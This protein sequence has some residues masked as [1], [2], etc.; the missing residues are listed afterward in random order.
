MNEIV[1]PKLSDTMTE[2]RLISWK[3]RVGEQVS[4]GEVL[5]EVE[6]DKANMELEAFVSGVLLEIRVEPG[7]MVPVGTVIAAIGAAEE[8]GQPA[9]GEKEEQPPKGAEAQA[10]AQPRADEGAKGETTAAP[11]PPEAG[12][13]A[14][15]APAGQPVESHE[16]AAP[17]VRRRARE[18]G[19]DLATVQGSG[20]EGRILLKDL[21]GAQQR[22]AAGKPAA[23]PS[24]PEG[25]AQP[26]AA[27]ESSESGAKLSRLR[28]A[29][30]K[31]VSDSWRAIPH[32]AVTV[33]VLMDDAEV[34]RRQLK[35]SGRA[36]T[37]TDL[38]VKA[39]ALALLKYPQL[40]ASL[41]GDTLRPRADLNICVAVAVPDGV[42]M[43]VIRG[44]QDLT[45]VEIAEASHAI[46][47]KARS[48]NLTEQDM[49]G[50][51]FAV[52]NLGMYGVTQFAA[53]IFP[54]HAAV[55]AVGGVLESV[56][57]RNGAPACAK[58]MKVTISADHRVVDGA[59][60]AQFLAEFKEILENPIR[61]LI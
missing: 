61:L 48:G 30:A 1:M 59:Y 31:N 52:S 13:A 50:G 46:A 12:G 11:P 10:P 21:E 26:T 55:L 14:A 42:L 57:A 23:P 53:I 36:V 45:L 49:N 16:R 35:Q 19:V 33:D 20:P 15:E 3:K 28:A 25:A 60:A 2:G 18:L 5:A 43:P 39:S 32:F 56:V 17:V 24:M 7:D 47:E 40:N 54:S 41:D 44:C 38:V 4:R 27:S 6:T 51:S 9:A 58:V 8:K 22:S 37:L 34:M 29:I